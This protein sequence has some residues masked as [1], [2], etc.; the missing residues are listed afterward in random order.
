MQITLGAKMASSKTSAAFG[1][2]VQMAAKART[3]LVLVLLDR[4]S[5]QG[6]NTCQV[7]NPTVSPCQFTCVDGSIYDLTSIRDRTPGHYMHVADDGQGHEYF[8]GV[9]SQLQGFTCDSQTASAMQTWG[10]PQPPHF[11]G[12]CA[13]LGEYSNMHCS[14]IAP[15]PSQPYSS[16]GMSCDF[17][18]GEGGRSYTVKYNCALQ[19]VQPTASQPGAYAYLISMSSPA[20]CNQVGPGGGIPIAAAPP[21]PPK[22]QQQLSCEAPDGHFARFT[23]YMD[24]GSYTP[25]S[26]FFSLSQPQFYDNYHQANLVCVGASLDYKISCVGYDNGNANTIVELTVEKHEASYRF[27]HLDTNPYAEPA[28]TGGQWPCKV[29]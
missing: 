24:S 11:Y 27:V 21:P 8:V 20:L 23:A 22:P 14:S 18:G 7:T 1:S 4:V 10:S 5:A 26:G 6:I 16:G 3:L 25:G 15:L 28:Q 29:I 17:S 13:T 12:N 9:C 2:S 19:D